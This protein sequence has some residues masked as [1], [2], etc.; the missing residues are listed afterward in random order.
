MDKNWSEMNKEMQMLIAKKP[1]F[2]DGIEALLALRKSLFEQIT[3][4]VTTFPEE[5]FWQMPYAGA[6]GYHSKTLAY[7]I[8]HIFRIEDIVAHEMIAED[9]QVLLSQDFQTAIHSPIITTG[10][11]LSGDEIAEFSRQLD[12]KALYRYAQEVMRSTDRILTSLDYSDLK[13]RFGADMIEKLRRT[14]CVSEAESAAWLIGYWCGKDVQGLI[15]MPFSRHWIMHIEAMRRIKNR[16][17]KLARKGVDP[18]AFCGLSCNHCFLSE[19]CGSCRTAYN[20]CSFATVSPDRKCPNAVC[21]REKG[22]D[23]CWE[24]ELLETCGKGFYV[25]SNDGANAAK[26]QAMYIR[27]HGKKAFLKV[28]DRLHERY[29][30]AKVQEILGQ[31]R[32]EGLQTLEEC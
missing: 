22:I 24:C 13:R 1:T 16:L 3:Q 30:F 26:A 6:E 2:R 21:C 25:P 19:W 8:W 5:A 28:Q 10:N 9:Q 11:E 18:V 29:E 14:G 20:T 7:S 23:G 17:C 32:Q 12:I 4:I 31:D 27:K 15:R